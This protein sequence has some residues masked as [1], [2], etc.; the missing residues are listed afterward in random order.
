MV[1][2]RNGVKPREQVTPDERKNS[3]LEELSKLDTDVL[4][5]AYI[6]AKDFRICGED[7]TKTWVNTIQNNQ[8][9]EEIYRRGY[10]DA[11]KD[12]EQK[13]RKDFYHKV[14]VDLK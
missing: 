1:V 12:F 9:V 2:Q 3:V 14:V 6:Y 10:E 8:L 13:R 5:L 4:A 11:F 7:V